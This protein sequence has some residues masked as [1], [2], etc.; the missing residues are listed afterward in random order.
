GG[1]GGGG[2]GGVPIGPGPWPVA[3]LTIYGAAQGL[4]GGILDANPDDGQNIWATTR[5]TLYLL[6]PGSATF[7]TFHAADGLHIEPFTDPYGNAN[8]T[9]IT[10]I[11][12]GHAGEVLVGYYGYETAG[13]P[14]DDT[15]AQKRLGN[16]DRVTVDAAGHLSVHRYEFHCDYEAANGCWEN[17]SPRRIQYAHSGTAAGHSFWGFNH[18]VSHV[19]DD[20][21]GDHVHPE[22]WYQPGHVEKLGEFYGI[23]ILPSGDVW[24]A[25]RY[26]VGLQ[27]FNPVP[28]FSWVDG[29]FIYAFTTNTADHGLDVPTGYAENNRGAA[30]TPD[31]VVWLAR[32]GG[33]LASWDPATHNYNTIRTWS[34]VPSDLMDAQADPDGTLWLVTSGGALLRFDP[35]S[36]SVST[37]GGVSNVTRIY[38]D[39]TVTPR[40]VYASMSG[41][42]AVIRAK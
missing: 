2:G 20:Q 34:Q 39:S 19:L 3:D 37:F 42:L 5:D 40:A 14:Y 30:V 6:R 32:L 4:G 21:V 28:H 35:G 23:A 10:A 33:G 22:I 9:Y 12:G 13:N 17:R 38:V 15:D 8:Q 18:G 25:G 7:E 11:A 41:G 16:G 24:M 26:G 36:G 27:P 31:G 1:G 29:R